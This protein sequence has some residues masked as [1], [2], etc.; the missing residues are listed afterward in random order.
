MRTP[1]YLIGFMGS[2]KSTLGLKL[3]KR[4]SFPFIDLD[5]YISSKEGMSISSIF[6]QKGEEAFRMIERRA[7]IELSQQGDVVIACGGGTPCFHDNIQKMN[8]TGTTIYLQVEKDVLIGRLM[9]SATER[10]LIAGMS[11]AEMNLFVGN[12]LAERVQFYEKARIHLT[13]NAIDPRRL[14]EL[15][16]I[17]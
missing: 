16:K 13:G 3:S 9:K 7:L 10:P 17:G 12:L 14:V 8:E 2:G 5:H 4:L 6:M 11:E 1:I 15:I